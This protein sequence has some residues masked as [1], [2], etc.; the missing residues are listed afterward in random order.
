MNLGDELI[1]AR[2]LRRRALAAAAVALFVTATPRV[3]A[4]ARTTDDSWL[5]MR[6][7]P[8]R[9]IFAGLPAVRAP[10]HVP[11]AAATTTVENCNNDGVGSL[12]RAIKDAGDGDT[13][14]LTKLNCATITL[15][16]GAIWIPVD[17][18]T[19]LGPGRS[20]LAIDGNQRDRVFIH[21][22]GG[23]LTFSA[24]TVRHGR[25]R[26]TGFHVAGGG[27]IA[28]AGY[29]T[30]DAT[31]V[32]GCYAGGEGSYGGGIYAYSLTMSNSTLSENVAKGVHEDAGTAAFGGGAFVYAMD[33]QTSTVSGNR[34]VHEVRVGRSTYD[35][36]GALVTV[37]GGQIQN[38]T[39]EANYSQ[40]R[41]GGIAA[42][43]PVFVSNST[44]SGNVA[45][46]YIGGALLMRW[47]STVELDNS[48]V[49]ANY[50]AG[51]GGGIWIGAAGSAIR[52]SIVS[53][54]TSGAGHAANIEAIV[55]LSV[56]GDH[57]IIGVSNPAIAL[58]PD[59]LTSA[60][61]L[62]PL[63]VNGG[64]TLTHA[65]LSGSPAID[66]GTNSSAASFDQRGISYARSYGA[67]T[68]IG[69]FEVQAPLV[70]GASTPVPV[71]SKSFTAWLALLIGAAGCA[72]AL[73][74]RRTRRFGVAIPRRVARCAVV[75][76][77]C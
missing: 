71:M 26:A 40:Q 24:L 12:R 50:A 37:V 32:T 18:L 20:L 9:R 17:S 49:T 48:T 60:P 4:A 29:L 22:H 66:T 76:H 75:K 38:S 7:D 10:E 19:L 31:T 68:D 72:R 51:G 42:F 47:P 30:L 74:S 6:A 11:T 58:P 8:A 25:D 52:S 64:P 43:N 55:T 28:S 27:C 45:A 73:G 3:D 36:G 69:A 57:D 46:G 59:T 77:H 15:E 41:G 2:Y 35:I 33:L 53:G 61:L 16:T 14:D 39:I 65:L 56:D 13:I 23:A 5:R 70:A 44:L 54:N 67:S 63:A 62:G 21:P 34:A 1:P